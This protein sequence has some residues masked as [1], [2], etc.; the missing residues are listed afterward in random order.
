MLDVCILH[1]VI[2]PGLIFDKMKKKVMSKCFNL[3]FIQINICHSNNTLILQLRINGESTA[4]VYEHE[5]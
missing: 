4:L 5:S 1:Q 3:D 2:S